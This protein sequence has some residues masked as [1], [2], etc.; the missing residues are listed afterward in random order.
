MP[1]VWCVYPFILSSTSSGF[2]ALSGGLS[3]CSGI[4]LHVGC[5][6]Y[7]STFIYSGLFTISNILLSQQGLRFHGTYFNCRKIPLSILTQVQ[8]SQ[9]F[10]LLWFPSIFIFTL[11]MV[12]THITPPSLGGGVL[13]RFDEELDGALAQLFERDKGGL[14]CIQVFRIAYGSLLGLFGWGF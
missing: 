10:I 2:D 12:L 9:Y 11:V 8:F 6:N 3:S 5:Q 13:Q 7:S 4:I 14:I 1:P